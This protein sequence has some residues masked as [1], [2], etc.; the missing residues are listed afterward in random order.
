MK[1]MNDRLSWAPT[2]HYPSIISPIVSG[3]E[4]RR[5]DWNSMHTVESR[6]KVQ[7]YSAARHA[8]NYST[9]SISPFG[10]S[11][12][13]LQV[14]W[15]QTKLPLHKALM[16]LHPVLFFQHWHS[17][18]QGSALNW[19]WVLAP[20]DVWHWYMSRSWMMS[21][22]LAWSKVPMLLPSLGSMVFKDRRSME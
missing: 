13:F 10:T 5:L 3:F 21:H 6:C 8:R 15:W 18:V 11:L 20:T 1:F 17:V 14:F 7:H 9:L 2:L 12:G 22:Q 4:N 16:F 19:D